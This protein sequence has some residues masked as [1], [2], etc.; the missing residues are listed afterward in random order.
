MKAM[1]GT[2]YDKGEFSRLPWGVGGTVAAPSTP[3]GKY[4]IKLVALEALCLVDSVS[5]HP[6]H[7]Q[8]TQIY[9]FSESS[10][11]QIFTWWFWNY[12][13]FQIYLFFMH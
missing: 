5:S 6:S 10:F 1:V 11:A 2:V 4:V 9:D 8:K 3:I 13:L 12:F 7:Q